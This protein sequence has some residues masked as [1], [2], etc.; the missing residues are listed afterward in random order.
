MSLVVFVAGFPSSAQAI[1]PPD[2]IFNLGSQIPQFL[3]FCLLFI[4]SSVGMVRTF[5]K[6]RWEKVK[7]KKWLWAVLVIVGVCFCLAL[8]YVVSIIYYDMQLKKWKNDGRKIEVKSSPPAT[9]GA[10]AVP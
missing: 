8:S 3:G 5:F 2:F 1:P 9:P 6:T 7:Q 10:R 4:L